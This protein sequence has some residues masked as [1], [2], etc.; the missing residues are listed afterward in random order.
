MAT[1]SDRAPDAFERLEE[2]V[3]SFGTR[4]V[5]AWNSHDLDALEAMVTEDVTW[6]DPAMRGRT[7]HGRAEFR[8]FADTFFTAFPDARV[9]GIG[10][11]YV[12]LEGVG[13]AVRSRMTGTFTG[14]LALWGT[15]HTIAPTGRPFD[16]RGVDLYD[17]RGGLVSNW[18]IVYDLADFAQQIGLVPRQ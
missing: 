12:P 10:A 8:A 7:V 18:T 6:E 14:E 13:F 9:E 11:A 15:T 4:W 3:R 2:V 17:L 5:E 1:A 16:I